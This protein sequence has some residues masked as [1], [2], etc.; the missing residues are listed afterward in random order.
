MQQS[1]GR[2]TPPFLNALKFKEKIGVI[3]T[4]GRHTYNDLFTQSK[5]LSKKILAVTQNCPVLNPLQMHNEK[6]AFLCSNNHTYVTAQWATWMLGG[7]A[8]P[9]SKFH[10]LK[11][12]EYII[13]DSSPKLI[14]G[15]ENYSE[16]LSEISENLNINLVIFEPNLTEDSTSIKCKNYGKE[17]LPGDILSDSS[18]EKI[19]QGID[20]NDTNA[21]IVYTSGTTGRP[22][23]VVT[24]FPNLFSQVSDLNTTWKVSSDDGYLHVLPLHHVHGIVNNLV[25]PLTAG[26]CITMLDGFNAKEV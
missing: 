1:A 25:S 4:F 5:I 3:D 26:A 22:K 17:G 24:S 20:W 7:T 18:L 10:P 21:Q 19:W 23:G 16:I 12:L 9:L 6:V 2:F 14:V 8:V 11:E 13:N 15:T